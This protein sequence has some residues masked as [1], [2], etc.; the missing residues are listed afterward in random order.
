MINVIVNFF[1]LIY[2]HTDETEEKRNEKYTKKVSEL[3]FIV[4]IT[5]QL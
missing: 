5:I 1:F 3:H 2:S 4:V